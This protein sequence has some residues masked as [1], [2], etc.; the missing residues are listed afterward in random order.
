MQYKSIQKFLC[1]KKYDII[2]HLRDIKTKH[3]AFH[4]QKAIYWIRNKSLFTGSIRQNHCISASVV[5]DPFFNTHM[6]ITPLFSSSFD[7]PFPSIVI[8]TAFCDP[9]YQLAIK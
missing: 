5:L 8:V 9:L 6:L 4:H 7:S 1:V 3:T 2:L